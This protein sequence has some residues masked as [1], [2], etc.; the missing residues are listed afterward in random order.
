M[1]GPLEPNTDMAVTFIDALDPNGRRDLV[2]IDPELPARHPAKIEAATFLPEDNERM[3]AFIDTR[4]G[5]RNLY[6]SVNRAEENAPSNERLNKA[7]IGLIRAVVADIDASKVSGGDPSGDHFHR[8][9]DRLLGTV[10]KALSDD[11]RC[12]PSLV[13]DSGGGLQAWW[14]LRP[15]LPATPENIEL[16]EGIGRTIQKRNGGDSVFD[17]ARIMRLPGTINVLSPDKRAQGRDP[18]VAEV[19]FEHSRSKEYTIE[20]MKEW[21]PPTADSTRGSDD[22]AGWERIEMSAVETDSYGDL[23]TALRDKF[24]QYCDSRPSVGALWRG[25]ET[26]GDGS[27]SSRVYALA[28][29]LRGPGSFTITEFAQ[30]V[31]VWEFRSEKHADDFERYVSRSWNRNPTPRGGEGFDATEPADDKKALGATPNSKNTEATSDAWDAPADFRQDDRDPVDLPSGVVPPIVEGVARDHALRLGVEPGGPAA[32]I[33]TA[34]G[35]LVHAGNSL[36]MRQH[37]TGWTV[38]PVLWTAIVAD[39]GANKTATLGYA[40]RPVKGIDTTLAREYALARRK[41]EAQPPAAKN[42]SQAGGLGTPFEAARPEELDFNAEKPRLRQKI[43]NNATTEAIAEIL[44]HNPSG[45]LS[46]R[47]ELAGFFG[48]MDAY[49]QKGGIDRPFWLEAKDGGSYT[50][51][52]K[53]SEPLVVEN[54]AVCVLG[55]IQPE[56]MRNM[57]GGLASDGLLQRRGCLPDERPETLLGNQRAPLPADA[58]R[59]TRELFEEAERAHP[60][61]KEPWSGQVAEIEEWDQD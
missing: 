37:D 55:A 20:E 3:R 15:A 4:Q 14:K 16:V 36:Q 31:A 56:A 51:N 57:S 46:Y 40:V 21:A 45:I 12:P 28:G 44:A 18:A 1:S 8:E 7:R 48:G 32:A 2:A 26:P 17:V 54:N 61:I 52:R 25:D 23:P 49:R 38:R 53:T 9:R 60:A 6:V 19:M 5:R 42:K 30:L 22:K 34:M 35:S 47:D 10:A 27:P 13:V 43:I 39:S 33:I 50:V 24:E 11:A 41:F 29:H 59:L 58:L